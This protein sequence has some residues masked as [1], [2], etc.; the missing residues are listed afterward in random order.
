[1]ISHTR[2]RLYALFLC[3]GALLCLGAAQLSPTQATA[4][5]N[6]LVTPEVSAREAWR[7]ARE[8]LSAFL[9]QPNAPEQLLSALYGGSDEQRDVDARL[10][11]T[12]VTAQLKALPESLR[13]PLVIDATRL[14]AFGG[15]VARGPQDE[16]VVL[17][18]E[19]M[20]VCL[21]QLSSCVA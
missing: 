8:S 13:E 7:E 1:M 15:F 14:N 17:L 18:A 11:I 21:Y 2:S 10:A 9:Q 5:P 16:P 20:G 3:L 4:T 19:R 12:A 6:A